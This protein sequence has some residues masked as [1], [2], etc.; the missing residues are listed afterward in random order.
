MNG[1]SFININSK[2]DAKRKDVDF[3]GDLSILS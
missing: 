2:I 1:Y 3:Q